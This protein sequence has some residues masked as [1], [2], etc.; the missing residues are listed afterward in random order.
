MAVERLAQLKRQVRGLQRKLSTLARNLTDY[1][2]AR[3]AGRDPF[4]L[5]RRLQK[6]EKQVR[7]AALP[8]ALREDLLRWIQYE[9]TL[10]QEQRRGYQVRFVQELAQQLEALGFRLEGQLPRLYAGLYQIF[11]S[12]EQGTVKLS[13]GPEPVVTLKGLDPDRVVRALKEHE[14]S[15]QRPFVAQEFFD[16]LVRA[17]RRARRETPGQ[18]PRVPLAEVHR[19]LTLMLQPRSFWQ[20]PVRSRFREYPRT[21]FAY[22]LYRLRRSSLGPR[23]RLYVATFDQTRDPSRALF[24]PD[25]D[26][27]GTRYAYLVVEENHAQQA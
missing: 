8:D 26:H 7:E 22:D 27:R 9:H 15:L 17:Y 23:I 5:A 16:L 24:V 20:N 19:Q 10:L 6:L 2:Q 14:K 3:R 25:S 4:D 18:D 11:P 13:W 12:F 1:E 21:H